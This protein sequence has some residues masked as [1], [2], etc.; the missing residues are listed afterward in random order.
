MILASLWCLY[1]ASPLC[2]LPIPGTLPLPREV[3][4]VLLPLPL[5]FHTHTAVKLSLPSPTSWN[6]QERGPQSPCTWA[7]N[8][9]MSRSG[10]HQQGSEVLHLPASDP[11]ARIQPQSPARTDPR[12][13]TPGGPEAPQPLTR[14]LEDPVSHQGRQQRSLGPQA[15]PLSPSQFRDFIQVAVRRLVSEGRGGGGARMA[16]PVC[17]SPSRTQAKMSQPLGYRGGHPSDNPLS[18]KTSSPRTG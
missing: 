9:P 5:P 15:G 18:T 10:P 14:P 8:R 1:G 7:P 12:N 16:V 2:A 4:H 11:G 13:G 6:P 17:H 3:P